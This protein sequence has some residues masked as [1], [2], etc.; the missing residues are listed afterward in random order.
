[1]DV[2]KTFRWAIRAY[3]SCFF[4]FLLLLAVATDI[5][6]EVVD[7]APIG[8]VIIVLLFFALPYLAFAYLF[9]HEKVL[10]RFMGKDW[11]LDVYG[12]DT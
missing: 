5:A 8:A 3:V 7:P 10:V 9:P 1:M 4:L 11:R 2:Q 12:D 6:I